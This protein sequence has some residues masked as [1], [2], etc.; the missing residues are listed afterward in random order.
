M[1]KYPEYQAKLQNQANVA[2]YNQQMKEFAA[3]KADL[4]REVE[5][6]NKIREE[7]FQ[8]QQEYRN[9]QKLAILDQFE[10]S[11]KDYMQQLVNNEAAAKAAV[12]SQNRQYD[13]RVGEA[14]E[15][16]EDLRIGLQKEVRQ[17]FYNLEQSQFTLDQALYQSESNKARS[18]LNLQ[19]TLKGIETDRKANN[20]QLSEAL[21]TAGSN[22]KRARLDFKSQLNSIRG[23]ENDIQTNR[24]KIAINQIEINNRE[25]DAVADRNFEAIAADI[26]RIVQSGS[27]RALGRTG[28]S[29]QNSLQST[30]ASFAV[31]TAKIEDALYRS[32]ESLKLERERL[33]SDSKSLDTQERLLDE[34]K[35]LNFESLQLTIKDQYQAEEDARTRAN[36]RAEEQRNI[37][38]ATKKQTTLDILDADQSTAFARERQKI[39]MQ[40]ILDDLDFSQD[41]FQLNQE[42]LGESILSAAEAR[43]YA[44][45]EIARGKVMADREADAR[46]MLP[47]R[48]AP[49]P[50]RPY[51]A[52]MPTLVPPPEPI[53]VSKKAFAIEQPKKQSG[54]SKVLSIGGAILGI[55]GAAFTGGASLGLGMGLG[56]A[57]TA[58]AVGI[59]ASAASSGL[60][61][62]SQYT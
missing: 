53:K 14:R 42:R 31:N 39:D 57:A 61:L 18:E 47:P 1:S 43:K 17:G 13:Q 10:R 21:Y 50:P 56:S 3:N 20:Q 6:E 28:T 58:G 23:A 19:T 60:G 27:A 35:G 52:E 46:R 26:E 11:R 36:I 44:M 51:K 59:G 2:Q 12:N 45:S 30:L 5:L 54:L 15:R 29:S 8:Y 25:R 38:D 49:D 55:A 48:F 16:S 40:K 24:E 41:I 62:I 7:T 4:E 32:K 37:G 9:Q 34:T 22:R 33:A